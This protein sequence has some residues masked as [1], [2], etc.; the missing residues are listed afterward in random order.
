MTAYDR[1]K[2]CL[3]VLGAAGLL[4]LSLPLWVLAAVAIL[5]GY[6]RP[7]LFR[8]ARAGRDGHPFTL[9]KF[10]TMTAGE[11]PRLPDRPVA[12]HAGDSRVTPLGRLLRRT[13]VDELPQLLNVLRGEMSLVGPR[14]LPV[15][16]LAHPGW[17][18]G[19]DADERAR[20]LDWVARR[21]SMLPGLTGLWQISP[22]AEDD[23][24]NWI[25]CDLA[26]LNRRS[27]LLDL[28]ILLATPW[29]L[30]RGRKRRETV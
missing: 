13:A 23:F 7:I 16:D 3:D 10:R 8:Q 25:V 5:L 1:C 6:G 14:P 4:L 9:L 22:G 12:K 27:L 24:E 2:R 18:E 28:R 20:R 11:P 21:S 17:L 29:A 26:Y 15:E 30:L 19:I